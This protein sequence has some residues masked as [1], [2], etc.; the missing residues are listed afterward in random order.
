MLSSGYK[1]WL[2]TFSEVK[3]KILLLTQ[4]RF[5][6]ELFVD[7]VC[8][9]TTKVGEVATYEASWECVEKWASASS[10]VRQGL[11]ATRAHPDVAQVK[12]EI[13]NKKLS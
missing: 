1:K 13:D 6:M 4:Q 8:A 9:D 3:V 12:L 11:P 5:T 2:L 10:N 7:I